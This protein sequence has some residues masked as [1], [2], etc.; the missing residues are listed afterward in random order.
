MS[1]RYLLL[2]AGL[3]FGWLA[4][5]TLAFGQQVNPINL[6]NCEGEISDWHFCWGSLK[7]LAPK[8]VE[9]SYVGEFQDGEPSG[10]GKLRINFPDKGEKTFYG[11]FSEGRPFGQGLVIAEN[12]SRQFG[13]WE[14]NKFEPF[15]TLRFVAA[16]R[17]SLAFFEGLAMKGEVIE[18]PLIAFSHNPNGLRYCKKR[19]GWFTEGIFTQC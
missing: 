18:R 6:N 14:A 17:L 3:I 8:G 15:P 5:Y 4:P 9:T 16:S 12:G 13:V 7:K 10:L 11:E 19:S 2:G 1:N